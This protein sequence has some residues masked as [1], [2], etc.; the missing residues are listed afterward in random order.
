MNLYKDQLLYLIFQN[1]PA[2]SNCPATFYYPTGQP[3]AFQDLHQLVRQRTESELFIAHRD[4]PCCHIDLY[5]VTLLIRV[6]CL[7]NNQNGQALVH[8]GPE[9][10]SGNRFNQYCFDS[11]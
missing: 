6:N 7:R 5:L 1:F 3:S 8:R 10:Y 2:I 9:E 4:G 11:R